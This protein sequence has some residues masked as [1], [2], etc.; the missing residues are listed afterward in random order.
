M[1]DR[2]GVSKRGR[3]KKPFQSSAAVL[4]YLNKQNRPYSAI[5]ICNNLHKEFGKTAIVKACES[6]AE[7]GQIKEKAYGKQKVYVADQSQ[8]PEVDDAEV[9]TMDSKIV[10]LTGK[11]QSTLEEVRQL[12]SDLKMFSSCLST[13]EAKIQLQETTAQ[14]AHYKKKLAHLKDGGNVVSPEEKDKVYKNRET[15]VKAWKKRKRM[16][17]DIL[18]AILE[19]Y[20]KPKKQ[21][22][23]D[24]GIETDEDCSVKPPDI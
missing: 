5:D 4:D 1:V 20:P 13:E 18:N 17:N 11:L 10:E 22:Y 16:T 7:S 23:E 21:L 8:F 2:S 9:K 24:I 6:L 19:G 12:E 3:Q 14:C 15:Y